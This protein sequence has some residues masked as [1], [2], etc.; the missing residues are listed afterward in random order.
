MP[1][2][3]EVETVVRGLRASGL[4]GRTIRA[5][6]V[7]WSGAIEAPSAAEFVKALKGE[8][9]AEIARRGKYIVIR[10]GGGRHVLIHLRMTG[11]LRLVAASLPIEKHEHI[12][13]DLDDGSQLRYRDPRKFGRWCVPE[14]V[15]VRLGRLGPEPLDAS[16]TAE[17]FEE[18]LR[19]RQGMLKPLLLNQSFVAGLGN[20]YV[21]EA[22]WEAG[23][24]PRRKSGTLTKAER[25]RLHGAIRVVLR[26]GILNRG[27]TLGRG[28]TNFQGIGGERGSN[29]RGLNVF[30]RT[31][32]PCPR[33]G[34]PIVR[35]IVSQ[36]STHVC[37]RCQRG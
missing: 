4:A 16:F 32:E 35:L 1:E 10:L 22:L 36:R 12:I 8:R 7:R 18:R 33:C 27:T 34:T 31:G 11:R 29:Q 26:R 20:I 30:R 6:H 23:L 21:D 2:L 19:L 5:V 3:P 9:V 28:S 37:T 25:R 24:H 15:A 13:L 14:D 17:S